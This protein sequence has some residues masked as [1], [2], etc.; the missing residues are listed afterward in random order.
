MW[1]RGLKLFDVRLYD[2]SGYVAP[3]VGAWIETTAKA[4]PAIKHWSRP[5]WARGLKHEVVKA[6]A[7]QRKSR[8]M[9]ARG[10]KPRLALAAYV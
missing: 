9:W 6:N 5:M 1:A 4:K 7:E 10:L 8:P 3:H 2:Y